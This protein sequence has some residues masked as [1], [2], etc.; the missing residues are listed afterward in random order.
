MATNHV[1]VWIDHVSALVL[2]FDVEH[3]ESH[4]VVARSTHGAKQNGKRSDVSRHAVPDTHFFADVTE[5]IG[6]SREILI[7]GPAQA[8][9]E[10]AVY[11]RKHSPE[12]AKHIVGIEPLDHPTD[13]QI[14][15]FGR[16]YFRAKD[17]LLG[18]AG[19]A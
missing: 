7:V 10:F 3:Q 18:D 13:P 9:D 15:A 8:K 12:V 6:D 4:K 2:H 11:L 16:K 5:A 1:I 17:R 14:A 19:P